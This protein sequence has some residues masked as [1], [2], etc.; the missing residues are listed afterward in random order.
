MGSPF[1]ELAGVGASN[2]ANCAAH[3]FHV[4]RQARCG[5]DLLS[6]AYR[7]C[8]YFGSFG[9]WQLASCPLQRSSLCPPIVPIATLSVTG[10]LMW[11]HHGAMVSG[12]RW[13]GPP[14][15]LLSGPAMV[16]SS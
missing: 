10:D 11:L 8:R 3:P 6:A 12:M 16:L 9:I 14:I 2:V 13:A 7:W 1:V 4:R 5:R 15:A